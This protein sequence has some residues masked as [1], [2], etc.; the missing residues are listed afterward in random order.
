ML[1][2]AVKSVARL[3]IPAHVRVRVL[4]VENDT[5]P[6]FDRQGVEGF[7][8]NERNDMDIDHVFRPEI[9]IAMARNAALEYARQARFD[10]LAFI[11][12]DET[13]D[14]G[15]LERI[16]LA[17]EEGGFVLTGGPVKPVASHRPSRV[18]DRL[19]WGG[20]ERQ[21]RRHLLRAGRASRAGRGDRIT[22]ITN[23][24]LFDLNAPETGDIRFDRRFDLTGGEDTDFYRRAKQR[25][26][27][28]GWAP[29]AI[30]YE[31]IP[32][33]RL[34]IGYQFRR[35][36]NQNAVR[37]REKTAGRS[38]PTRALIIAM[39]CSIDTLAALLHAALLL[40][41]LGRTFY[42]AVRYFGAAVGDLASLGKPRRGFYSQVTEG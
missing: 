36:A 21:R 12:D 8:G 5:A 20:Y 16:L 27:K 1:V 23:N 42:G 17:A 35:A 14:H 6:T 25:G 37:L 29:A 13:V 40:P 15:W 2:A 28:S 7:F 33:E 4:I 31:T 39:R 38:L 22:I 10:W 26:A 9:G 32:A 18:V 34:T 24:W 3:R 19:I 11:D 30:A 41:T